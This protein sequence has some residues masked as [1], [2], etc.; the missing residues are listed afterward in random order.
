MYSVSQQPILPFLITFTHM[1]IVNILD[2]VSSSSKPTTNTH[3]QNLNSHIE[4]HI[5]LTEI[6]CLY[7]MSAKWLSAKWDVG[8][9]DIGPEESA[10]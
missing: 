4:I 2:L 7:N 6:T 1:F 8:S 9:L 5:N 10:R 3:Y